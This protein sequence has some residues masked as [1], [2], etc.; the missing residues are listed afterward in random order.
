MCPPCILLI[1]PKVYEESPARLNKTMGKVDEVS[2][3]MGMVLGLKK[4]A[5]AHARGGEVIR[6]GP[7]RL[8]PGTCVCEI[9]QG[10]TYRYLGVHQL[11]VADIYRTRGAV[12]EEYKRRVHKI[13]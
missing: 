4:C 8:K 13:W 5:V 3:A 11:L 1:L 2:E 7:L 9:D 12:T 6:R 10:E